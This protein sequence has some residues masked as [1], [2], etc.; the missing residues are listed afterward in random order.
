M[1]RSSSGGTPRGSPAAVVDA[2]RVERGLVER[3]DGGTLVDGECDM[4]ARRV[5]LALRDPERGLVR[6]SEAHR[7]PFVERHDNAVAERREGTLVEGAA[8]R[9]VAD[10][11]PNVVEHLTLLFSVGSTLE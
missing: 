2:A 3:V 5:R 4:C 1:R 11:H 6:L 8:R 10:I 7:L 9:I